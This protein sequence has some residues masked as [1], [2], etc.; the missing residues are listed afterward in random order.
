MK[1]ISAADQ[2]TLDSAI[3][4][5]NALAS[6][7]ILELDRNLESSADS[8]GVPDSPITPSSPSKQGGSRFSFKWVMGVHIT[9]R[10]GTLK[11]SLGNML[12]AKRSIISALS[13]IYRYK[14]YELEN[15]DV[16]LCHSLLGFMCMCMYMCF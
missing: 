2:R 13:L 3:A 11:G 7:S 6:K 8:D 10:E 16:C 4:M 12:L 9:F 15:I 14:Y 5:A 1:P